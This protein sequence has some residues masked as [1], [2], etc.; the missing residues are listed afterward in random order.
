MMTKQTY[1]AVLLTSLI[2]GSTAASD[3]PLGSNRVSDMAAPPDAADGVADVA[4]SGD[5]LV[6]RGAMSTGESEVLLGGRFRLAGKLKAVA[7]GCAPPD[8][9]APAEEAL[10]QDCPAMSSPRQHVKSNQLERLATMVG[11]WGMCEEVA[12][13]TCE[14]DI[15]GDGL[16]GP[17]DVQL[18]LSDW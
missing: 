14:S 4:S 7:D 11:Q 18:L 17:A 1:L 16:V 5:G 15:D 3:T 12:G 13:E 6:L 2:I 9:T 8:E 10:N